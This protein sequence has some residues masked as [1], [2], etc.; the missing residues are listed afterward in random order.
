MIVNPP[1]SLEEELQTLLPALVRSLAEAGEGKFRL[2][3]LA[4]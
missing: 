3:W 4:R 2:G 1:W